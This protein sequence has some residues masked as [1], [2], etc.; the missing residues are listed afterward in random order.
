MDGNLGKRT[1]AM[2]VGIAIIGLSVGLYRLSGFG[3]DAFTC[4]NLGISG[5]LN[6][7]FGSWQLIV[8]AVIL[9][10]VFFLCRNAS[11]REQ[12]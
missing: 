6:M 9:I 10:A 5:F 8:N 7:G 1:A 3:V 4:M 11:A 12:S 2:A